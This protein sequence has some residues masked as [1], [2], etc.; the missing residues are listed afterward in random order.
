MAP[1][2][3][4]NYYEELC[5][6]ALVQLMQN[7]AKKVQKSRGAIREAIADARVVFAT[8]NSNIAIEPVD[9]LPDMGASIAEPAYMPA[10]QGST[11]VKTESAVDMRRAAAQATRLDITPVF[12]TSPS[13]TLG[14]TGNYST[15]SP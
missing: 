2:R 7:M 13:E 11:K 10:N 12:R 6:S 1:Q 9:W 8:E 4:I 5:R 15:T 3:Q 14:S